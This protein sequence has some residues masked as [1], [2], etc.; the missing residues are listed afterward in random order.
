[1]KPSETPYITK[2]TLE[3]VRCFEN[4]EMDLSGNGSS[5]I[6]ALITGNN[7]V[8]KSSILRA[9]AMGLCDRG[10]AGALLRELEGNY[11][12]KGAEEKGG[13]KEA[14]V[15][16]K[17]KDDCNKWDIETTFTEEKEFI[18]EAIKQ[19]VK[20]NGKEIKKD[21][22][23]WKELFLIAYGAGLRTQGTAK[24]SNYF[25]PD[26]VYSLFKYDTHL[27]DPELAWRRLRA[28]EAQSRNGGGRTDEL[29]K[30]L[31]KHILDLEEDSEITLEPNGIYMRQHGET[32]PL[33]SVGDGHKSLVK[34]TLDILLWYLLKINYS[35]TEGEER[36]W[37]PLPLKNSVL[38]AKGIV[39]I[40]EIEQ[41]LHPK[42]Q[43]EILGRLNEKF[44]KIQFIITTHSPLCVTGTDDVKDGYKIFSVAYNEEEEITDIESVSTP[45][46]LFAHQVLLD[47]F[48]LPTTLSVS[49]GEIYEKVNELFLKEKRTEKEE[50]EYKR[51]KK[52]INKI[53]PTLGESVKERDENKTLI[54]V[55]K[56]K[57]IL[58][59]EKYDKG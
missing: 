19:V 54:R 40:D 42:L 59:R 52:E 17:L 16:I 26:A 8:G 27:Q 58:K 34:F 39:I 6:S 10:S 7:G 50:K 3:N 56:N 48:G 53:S 14:K 45:Q 22:P 33:D 51:L 37:E 5:G 18:I 15:K 41:H 31:L 43:R 12:R 24:Y 2:I 23:F 38:D 36:Y 20:K 32:K 46:G 44:P 55:L 28:A 49:L 47:Y 11:V 29:V 35:E 30:G 25:A 1:M 4:V 57:R 21:A 9:I 13:K